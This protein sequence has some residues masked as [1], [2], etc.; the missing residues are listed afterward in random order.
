MSAGEAAVLAAL[1]EGL[2]NKEIARRLFIST[3]TVR[4][5][6][7]NIFRKLGVASRLEA[8]V[9]WRRRA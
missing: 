8:V 7:R 6:L 1:A 4:T 2:S 3:A 5:H 9:A